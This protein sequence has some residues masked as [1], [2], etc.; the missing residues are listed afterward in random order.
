MALARMRGRIHSTLPVIRRSAPINQF[1]QKFIPLP[2]TLGEISAGWRAQATVSWTFCAVT[3]NGG[4]TWSVKMQI[5]YPHT[6]NDDTSYKTDNFC[7]KLLIYSLPFLPECGCNRVG[8]QPGNC[9]EYGQCPCLPNFAGFRC[10]RC[11]KGYNSYP[12]CMR[13]SCLWLFIFFVRLS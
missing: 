11:A 9:D 13:K 4:N 8:S 3:W 1:Y 2:P 5:L 10:D 7:V 6:Y 12:D